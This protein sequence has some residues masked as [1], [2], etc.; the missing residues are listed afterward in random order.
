MHLQATTA[1]CAMLPAPVATQ[2]LGSRG[3]CPTHHILLQLPSTRMSKLPFSP[4]LDNELN[5][6]VQKGVSDID[7]L[8][9]KIRLAQ[10]LPPV[11]LSDQVPPGTTSAPVGTA[12][13]A[14][15]AAP[16]VRGDVPCTPACQPSQGLCVD[17]I[18][19]C[20]YPYAGESCQYINSALLTSPWR[21]FHR[22]AESMGRYDI[23]HKLDRAVPL[24]LAILFWCAVVPPAAF[25]GSLAKRC[26]GK[27]EHQNIKVQMDQHE[28]W[29]RKPEEPKKKK[30]KGR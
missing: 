27:R 8:T 12:A 6:A 26:C 23:S 7:A 22:L 19:L 5:A 11:S 17:G 9:A 28:A 21:V 16:A 4:S 13:P 15:T 14:S 25:L 30:K 3:A 2:A 18:C 29:V 10:G 1:L 24:P 20:K